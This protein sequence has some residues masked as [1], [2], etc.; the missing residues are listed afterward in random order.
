LGTGSGAIAL[1]LASER[2][3][4]EV[5]GTDISD[6]ALF[7]ARR[8]P[9]VLALRNVS[10]RNARGFEAQPD[11]PFDVLVSSP[12]YI[13]AG[14]PDLAQDVYRH[15]PRIA[16]ISGPTGLEAIDAIVRGA[17]RHLRPDGWLILEHGWKQ[18]AEVRALLV[19]NGFT[20]V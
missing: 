14:D 9:A 12:P 17:A 5:I 11:E 10:F 1:A 15:E 18:A 2:T 20:H 6:D 13:A 3:Q 4:A 7:V 16:L 19:Q 8:N